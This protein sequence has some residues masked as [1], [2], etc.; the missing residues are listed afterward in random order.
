MK[1][2][3]KVF[4]LII[5]LLSSISCNQENLR[6]HSKPSPDSKTYLVIED[7]NGSEC[8]P[9]LI[10]G[11]VWKYKIG[12]AGIINPGTHIIKCGGEIEFEIKESTIFYFDY[13]GP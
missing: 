3:V 2:I 1:T 13:W 4:A 12:E 5:F 11:E 10:D 7:D 8:G 6:G 9:I